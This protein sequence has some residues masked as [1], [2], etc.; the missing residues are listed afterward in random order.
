[1]S[2][3]SIFLPISPTTGTKQVLQVIVLCSLCWIIVFAIAGW[4]RIMLIG[5]ATGMAALAAVKYKALSPAVTREAGLSEEGIVIK[6]GNDR[7]VF[8]LSEISRI[9]FTYRSRQGRLLRRNDESNSLLQF[10]HLGK[11][12]RYGLQIREQDLT[13]LRSLSESWKQQGSSFDLVRE[14]R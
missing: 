11:D 5:C 3:N 12:H 1:M 4:F 2:K 14:D 9:T 8:L 13:S 7:M 10:V 6:N